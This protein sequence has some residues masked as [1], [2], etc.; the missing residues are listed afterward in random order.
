MVPVP[1]LR[2]LSDH[3][4]ST[5]LTGPPAQNLEERWGCLCSKKEGVLAV[6]ACL[7]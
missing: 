3:V 4:M 2:L 5:L 7:Q 6:A 1:L